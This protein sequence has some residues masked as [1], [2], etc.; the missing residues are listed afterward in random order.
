MEEP[1]AVCR[2]LGRI[3]SAGICVLQGIAPLRASQAQTD[4]AGGGWSHRHL[5]TAVGGD[6]HGWGGAGCLGCGERLVDAALDSGGERRS[7][8]DPVGTDAPVDDEAEWLVAMG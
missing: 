5:E 4:R 8:L 1:D 3:E 2:H 7:R 6:R